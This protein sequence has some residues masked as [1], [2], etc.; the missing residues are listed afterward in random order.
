MKRILAIATLLLMSFAL[1]AQDATATHQ[2]TGAKQD[3][4]AAGRSTKRATKKTVHKVKRTTKKGVHKA[5]HGVSKGASKTEQKTQTPP[6]P[7]Q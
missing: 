4:K 5:A 7:Q 1:Y 6:P 3:M 2:D